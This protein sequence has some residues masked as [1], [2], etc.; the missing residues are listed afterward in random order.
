MVLTREEREA[1]LDQKIQRMKIKNA[2]RMK[3]FQVCF[4]ILTNYLNTLKPYLQFCLCSHGFG[5]CAAVRFSA[6]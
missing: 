5:T 3:K 4:S 6:R 2:E 1:L